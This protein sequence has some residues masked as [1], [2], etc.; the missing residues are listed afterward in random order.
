MS[1]FYKSKLEK[2]IARKVALASEDYG[3]IA[4]NDR[5]AVAFSGG[6]D[7][8]ALLRMLS[9]I[10]VRGNLDI[11][12]MVINIDP[13]YDGY[14]TDIIE[15]YLREC[16]LDF[17]MISYPIYKISRRILSR[18]KGLCSFCA[19][20]RRGV[21]YD[22]CVEAGYNKLALGHNANDV[23]ET[24]LMNQMFSGAL[25]GMPPKLKADGKP[26][27]VIRPLY[28]VFEEETERYAVDRNAPLVDNKCPVRNRDLK[29][30]MVK[31]MIRAMVKINPEVKY[32]LLSSTGNIH[33]RFL[34]DPA[35]N[36]ILSGDACVKN[37]GNR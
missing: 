15:G 23:I 12:L 36:D 7:S 13:G 30:N 25:R 28:Y 3:L 16:G 2:D 24:L 26:I 29:R 17:E 5:I 18:D 6:K 11:R 9:I 4:K 34:S 37:D 8:F 31:E 32:C 20:L 22:Y 27:T 14:R 19:R 35:Y 21:L 33:S 10:A 1:N